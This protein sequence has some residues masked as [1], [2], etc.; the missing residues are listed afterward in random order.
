MDVGV[1]CEIH[2]IWSDIKFWASCASITPSSVVSDFSECA[3]GATT[4][5]RWRNAITYAALRLIK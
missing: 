5:Q 2:L 1:A 4:R 3:G